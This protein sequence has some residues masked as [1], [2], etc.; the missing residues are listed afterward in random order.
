M[1][2]RERER[3][4]KKEATLSSDDWTVIQLNSA[5]GGRERERAKGGGRRK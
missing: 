2:T 3:E 1:I 4:R 5:K